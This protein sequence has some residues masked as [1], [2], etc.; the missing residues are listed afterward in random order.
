[1]G[2][3]T[4]SVICCDQ[5]EVTPKLCLPLGILFSSP[6][7]YTISCCKFNSTPTQL[8]QTSLFHPIFR[9]THEHIDNW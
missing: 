4:A 1:M 5:S 7:D 8:E 3:S 6:S 2:L 9:A